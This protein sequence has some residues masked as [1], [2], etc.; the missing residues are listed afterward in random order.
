LRRVTPPPRPVTLEPQQVTCRA[1]QAAIHPYAP[2]A[3][4]EPGVSNLIGLAE[5]SR[6]L[7]ATRVTPRALDRS[8]RC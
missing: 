1:P 8:R 6:I 4:T 2:A 5:A 7:D 3:M